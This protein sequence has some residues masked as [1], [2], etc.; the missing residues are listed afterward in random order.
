MNVCADTYSTAYWNRYTFDGHCKYL[1]V[2]SLV[3][4]CCVRRVAW[5]CNGRQSDLNCACEGSII[6]KTNTGNR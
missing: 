3:C 1:N 2:V 4:N 5:C 6:A